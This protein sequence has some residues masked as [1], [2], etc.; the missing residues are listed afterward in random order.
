MTRENVYNYCDECIDLEIPNFKSEPIE[1][2]KKI[3]VI[4]KDNTPLPIEIILKIIEQ[5]NDYKICSCCRKTKLCHYHTQRSEYYGNYYGFGKSTL[6]S[7]C[8]WFHIS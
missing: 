8:C 4:L 6:C 7:N 5:S 3:E 1:R 2:F